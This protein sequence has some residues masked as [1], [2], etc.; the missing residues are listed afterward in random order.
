M[1]S[2]PFVREVISFQ[3]SIF[4]CHAFGGEVVLVLRKYFDVH[5]FLV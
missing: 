2:A 1:E 3:G 4:D 5:L